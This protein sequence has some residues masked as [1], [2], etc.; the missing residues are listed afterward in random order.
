[1]AVIA[2]GD[3]DKPD[4]ETLIKTHFSAIPAPPE[5]EAAARPTRCPTTPDTL[6]AIATDKEATM[7]SVERLQHAS[8]CA[9]R[10][11]SAPTGS[12]RSSGSTPGMLNARLSELTLKADPPFM[13]AA[14]DRGLFVRTKEAATLMALVKEDGIE[15]RPRRARHR[16]GAGP[17]A[18]GSPPTELERQKRDMLRF[19]EGAFAEKRQGGVGGS[20][21][22]V[23]PQL[24]AEGADSRHHL[25]VRAGPAL[26][27][28]GHAGRG[29]QGGEGLGRRQPRRAGERPAEAG[30]ASCRT[31]PQLAAV[32]DERPRSRASRR[33]WTS[34]RAARCSTRCRTPGTD[35]ED[36]DEGELR[37]HRVGA[38]ERREGRAEA[39]R[40]SSR[41]RSSSAPSAP[42]AR[43][44]RATRTTCP[45]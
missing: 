21:G 9:T 1:M 31:A 34:P 27:A 3:F 4:V 20:G 45:R 15:A 35:R 40:R 11:R 42:A 37:H 38:V 6:Y 18:S 30:P 7:T 24:H 26:R 39:D 32:I 2:V 33:T 14:T 36:D 19:Y 28:R 13:Q 44:S 23:H 22:R 29:Q 16:V 17:R 12:S 10:R 25:R 8:R 5:P 43:R 41:T